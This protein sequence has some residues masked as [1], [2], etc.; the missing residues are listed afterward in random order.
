MIEFKMYYEWKPPTLYQLKEMA[1]HIVF[2]NRCMFCRRVIEYDGALCE[3]C[4]SQLPESPEPLIL[5]G[6]TVYSPFI[7][8]E[9]AENAVKDLKFHANFTNARKLA[10]YMAKTI[11]N[12]EC[13]ID[14]IVPVP[15]HKKDLRAREFNQTELIAREIGKIINLPVRTDLLLKTKR[16][17]K[18]H[19]L[20]KKARMVNLDGAFSVLKDMSDAIEGK[21]LL[22]IDDVCTTGTTFEECAKVLL[23]IGA[24]A[25]TGLSASIVS[26][27]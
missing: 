22:I 4:I 21:R 23:D 8:R 26:T 5:N 25:V 14:Y 15:L 3:E 20:D 10:E 1:L 24:Q 7:Y 11:I 17:Q 9:G 13:D 2:P 18:Q 19:D 27:R 6:I 12:A 16:T